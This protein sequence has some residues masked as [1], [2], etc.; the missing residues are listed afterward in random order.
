MSRCV[1]TC[2]ELDAIVVGAGPNG[3]SA[4]VELAR[5]GRSV[6]VMEA[7]E[8][9]GGGTRTEELTRPGF[10]HDVCSAIH[11][12]AV[13]S[14]FFR[15]IEL[16]RF[17][18]EWVHPR[19]PLTH[20][21]ADG[22][23]AVLERSVPAT[24]CRLGR[25]AAAYTGLV[26]PLVAKIEPL[27]ADILKPLRLPSHPW[28]MAR[29]GVQ[30]LRSC[31][32]LVERGFAGH[33]ARA[34]IAGCGA[35]STVPLDRL[36]TAAFALTLLL[37]GHAF[38]WP[39]ARG[40]SRSI[41]AA[42]ASILRARGG[43]IAVSAPVGS[44]RDLP[45]HRAVLLDLTPRQVLRVAG[46]ERAARLPSE[47]RSVSLRPGG[48]QDRLGIERGHPVAAGGVSRERDGARR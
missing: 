17:G 39:C 7:A 9:L 28:L 45:R 46:A 47:P 12:L 20:P 34:L 30:G 21:L 31:R 19:L 33:R 36:G 32:D 18:V 25:D 15:S 8:E 48:V 29:F 40:G 26:D 4:A 35:H 41:T 13:A 3:L 24:A 6:L 22:D 1:L 23:V 2:M 44:L 5:A 43:E 27:L 38:G 10:K 14:P 11:P 16:E 37:A 42:L